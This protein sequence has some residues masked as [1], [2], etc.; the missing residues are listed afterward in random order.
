MNPSMNSCDKEAKIAI[1]NAATKFSQE[2]AGPT[3][4]AIYNFV[5]EMG[6]AISV[7]PSLIAPPLPPALVG[8]PCTGTIPQPNIT[9]M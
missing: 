1:E 6:I 4:T 5:K 8:G 7:P 3:A 2:A 9:I